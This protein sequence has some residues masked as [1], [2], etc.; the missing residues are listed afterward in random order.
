MSRNHRQNIGIV[1]SEPLVAGL[2]YSLMIEVFNKKGIDHWHQPNVV[3]YSP[4]LLE[5]NLESENGILEATETIRR[6]GVNGVVVFPDTSGITE[7][8][9]KFF[10]T[11]VVIP[12]DINA[13]TADEAISIRANF[14]KG[15]EISGD[16]REKL[17][18]WAEFLYT[19]TLGGQRGDCKSIQRSNEP[20]DQDTFLRARSIKR[21]SSGLIACHGGMSSQ[22]GVEF[23]NGLGLRSDSSIVLMS[24]PTTPDFVP[25]IIEMQDGGLENLARSLNPV[26]RLRD[27]MDKLG[28]LYP[29]VVISVCNTVHYFHDAMRD[30]STPVVHLPRTGVESIPIAKDGKK[31][32]VLLL[33]TEASIK[34]KIFEKA[35]EAAGRDDIEWL[36]PT[37]LQSDVNRAIWENIVKGKYEKGGE[38]LLE[39]VKIYN[40]VHGAGTFYVMAGCTEVV[41]GLKAVAAA[42]RETLISN[43]QLI[44]NAEA[45]MTTCIAAVKKVSSVAG[46]PSNTVIVQGVERGSSVPSTPRVA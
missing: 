12:N 39:V 16:L 19:P 8:P 30:W 44:D 20:L 1:T 27:T 18:R 15:E 34:G 4:K 26:R 37:N 24:V 17:L 7:I 21:H 22:A 6:L 11:G 40:K 32:K 42:S 45:A 36:I 10:R 13:I 33:A 28:S 3:L 41:M 31:T 2:I 29:D 35:A 46:M 9:S 23:F 5:V 25:G 14:Q 38:I 43:D